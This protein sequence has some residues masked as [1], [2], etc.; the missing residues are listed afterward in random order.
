MN[1]SDVKYL[2]VH[3]SYTPE[4]MDIGKSDIDR[5]HREKGWMMIGYHKVIKRD[6]T[7]EDGRPL[8]KSGAH[9]RGMNR[10]SIGI[11]LI[12]GMNRAKDGPEIN[13]TDEQMKSLRSLLDDLSKDYPKAKV[14][15]HTDFDKGKTCPNFDAG[16]W[17]ETDEIVST[18]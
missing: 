7:V 12:G 17:Y 6:G 11:C 1:K 10:T 15:G 16:K 4:S 13:Y 3:C 9:V 2:I 8:S 14:R 18:M 5:W